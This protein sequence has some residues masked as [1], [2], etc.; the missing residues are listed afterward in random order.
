MSFSKFA[1]QGASIARLKIAAGPYAGP[2]NLGALTPAHASQVQGFLGDLTAERDALM[3]KHREMS[4]AARAPGAN[5]EQM[6]AGLQDLE[7]NIVGRHNRIS[8]LH[9][10]LEMNPLHDEALRTG[11][12][13]KTL[14]HPDAKPGFIEETLHG[15]GGRGGRFTGPRATRA[16]GHDAVAD[17]ARTHNVGAPGAAAA[18]KGLPMWGKVGLGIGGAALGAMALN[19]LLSPS[20]PEPQHRPM[21]AYA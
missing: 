6:R 9:R 1:S 15:A 5:A 16:P 10:D 13:M 21:M 18:G 17:W 3:A 20:K 12:P 14:L 11:A 4:I 8:E 2:Q 7:Q 19:S